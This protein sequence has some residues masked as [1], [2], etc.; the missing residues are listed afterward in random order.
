[1]HDLH[2]HLDRF[3]YQVKVQGSNMG[4][5]RCRTAGEQS[6]QDAKKITKS[7]KEHQNIKATHP[8]QIFDTAPMT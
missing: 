6:K 7:R 8:S 5:G 3:E 2:V 1:M 4:G